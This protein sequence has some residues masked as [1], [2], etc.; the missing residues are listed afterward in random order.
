MN[1]YR[2][3]IEIAATWLGS[4]SLTEGSGPFTADAINFG[5]LFVARTDAGYT[6]A[7]LRLG[8]TRI[9]LIGLA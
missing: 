9:P 3:I 1:S 7:R 8:W 5:A 2:K 6:I 4:P